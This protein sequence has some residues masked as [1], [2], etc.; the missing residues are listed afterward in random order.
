MLARMTLQCDGFLQDWQVGFRKSRGWRDNTT[1]LRM[2]WQD[3]MRQGKPLTINFVDYAV[4]FDSVS[5][6]FLDTTLEKMGVSNKLIVM[7]RAVYASVS[8]F[9]TVPDTEGKQ[10]KTDEFTIKWG[11]IQGDILSPLLFILELES[12]LSVCTTTRRGRAPT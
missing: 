3:I 9:T 10:I 4:A 7:V 5:H 11:V 6:R 2:I 8:A 1:I 12:T